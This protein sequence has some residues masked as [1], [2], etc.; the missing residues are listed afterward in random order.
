MPNPLTKLG[1]GHSRSK[2]PVQHEEALEPMVEYVQGGNFN[3]AYRGMEDHG[4]DPTGKYD[5]PPAFDG[6]ADELYDKPEKPAADPVAVKIVQT[7]PSE[8]KRFRVAVSYAVAGGSLIA[9]RMDGRTKVR[10]LNAS[11]ST[12]IYISERQDL[13]NAANGYPITGQGTLDLSTDQEI[14]AGT[15]GPDPVKVVI[16]NEYS[17]E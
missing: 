16:I 11:A 3:N 1:T 13:A 4:V 17:S 14:Y 15:D 10:V 9:S 2:A 5:P 8:H 7:G 6:S 12:L